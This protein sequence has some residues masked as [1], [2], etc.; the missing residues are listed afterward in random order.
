V[1]SSGTTAFVADV[2]AVNAGACAK[3]CC[4]SQLMISARAQGIQAPPLIFRG[5]L[6]VASVGSCLR[7]RS[8]ARTV[9]L[10][11]ASSNPRLERA[12]MRLW[13]CAASAGRKDALAALV[14]PR[15]SAAQAH[16]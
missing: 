8:R 6:G 4:Y 7:R 9:V 14:G 13:L 1:N 3:T 11:E 15:R 12:V 16:R 10:C 2:A 5:A